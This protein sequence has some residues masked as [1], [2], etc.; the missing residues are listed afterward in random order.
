MK[1]IGIYTNSCY[2]FRGVNVGG[3]IYGKVIGSRFS[4]VYR[5]G[6]YCSVPNTTFT[7]IPKPMWEMMKKMN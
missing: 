2:T 4:H 1:N 6:N 5:K 7:K 3:H